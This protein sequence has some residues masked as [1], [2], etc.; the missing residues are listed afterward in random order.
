[1]EPCGFIAQTLGAASGNLEKAVVDLN[2]YELSWRPGLESNP[3]GFILWHMTRSEDSIVHG[4]L[5]GGKPQVWE[6]GKWGEKL[7]LSPDPKNS[8]NSYT[9]EQV[10]NFPACTAADLLDYHKA[11]RAATLEYLDTVKPEDLEVKVPF[12]GGSEVPRSFVLSIVVVEV[13]THAGQIGYLRGML[14]GLNK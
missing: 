5:M 10:A 2:A 7:G 9:M 1:M 13:G 6:T 11:V 14:R 8:G 4:L 3:I 12:F